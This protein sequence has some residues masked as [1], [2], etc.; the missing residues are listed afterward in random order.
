MIDLNPVQTTCF[1]SSPYD[2]TVAEI[3][4]MERKA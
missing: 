4:L 1:I 3:A 2:L